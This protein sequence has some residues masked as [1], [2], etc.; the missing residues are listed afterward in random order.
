MVNG[1]NAEVLNA[2]IKFDKD[3]NKPDARG[4]TPLLFAVKNDYPTEVVKTLL[5]NGADP[6][7]RDSNGK[8]AMDIIA[9]NQFFDVT[10]EEQIKNEV[11]EQ[12]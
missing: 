3:L 11:L 2:L 10:I 1:G 5:S 4:D 8:N 12:W 7:F 9:E 6:E